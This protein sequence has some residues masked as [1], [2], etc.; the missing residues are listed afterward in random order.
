MACALLNPVETKSCK[1][2]RV[3]SEA[4]GWL[5]HTVG[6]TLDEA[7]AQDVCW[8]FKKLNAAVDELANVVLLVA[9]TYL[10]PL[11]GATVFKS[12]HWMTWEEGS[13]SSIAENI[14]GSANGTQRW[15][16]SI[17]CTKQWISCSR[18]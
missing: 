14:G 4:D 16:S 2:S 12:P 9:L 15:R 6:T 10:T 13:F 8:S 18:R 17:T 3:G 1:K 5:A 11:F 7:F